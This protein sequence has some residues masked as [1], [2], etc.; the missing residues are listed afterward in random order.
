MLCLFVTRR[1]CIHPSARSSRIA[2]L[3]R[4]QGIIKA[5]DHVSN[6]A[7]S[8][9]TVGH[10]CCASLLLFCLCTEGSLGM[11]SICCNQR[12]LISFCPQRGAR[13]LLLQAFLL[14]DSLQNILK[15]AC[16]GKLSGA[17]GWLNLPKIGNIDFFCWQRT[18][19]SLNPK[20]NPE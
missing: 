18:S 14:A 4:Y 10:R 11:A 6:A 12:Y 3:S 2:P 15:I 9:R 8:Q 1:I 19:G 16:C 5:F 20:G 17:S 13:S 7:G